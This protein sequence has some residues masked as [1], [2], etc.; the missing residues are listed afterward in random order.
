MYKYIGY[1]RCVQEEVEKTFL[2]L[3]SRHL[4][5]IAHELYPALA[6]WTDSGSVF[7]V[8]FAKECRNE[9]LKRIQ[10]DRLV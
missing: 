5:A 8:S 7:S 4:L 2:Q 6:S 3:P 10:H 1:R 9:M